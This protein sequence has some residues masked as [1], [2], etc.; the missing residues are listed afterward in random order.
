MRMKKA[1]YL[2]NVF[3]LVLMVIF[4]GFVIFNLYENKRKSADYLAYRDELFHTSINNILGTYEEFSRFIFDTAINSESVCS[5]VAKAGAADEDTK[6]ELRSSLYEDLYDLYEQTQNY[7]FRQLHFHLSDGESFLRFHSPENFGDPLFPVRESVRIA[8][9]EKRF[10]SGFEE[11]RI[12]NGY[13]FVYPLFYQNEPIGSVEISVSVGS[14]IQELNDSALRRDVGF[15]LDKTLVESTVFSE[16][17]ERYTTSDVSEDYVY[18]KEV[19]ALIGDSENSL[20]LYED[21]AFTQ[22]LKTEIAGYLANKESFSLSLTHNNRAYLIQYD[23]ICDISGYPAGYLFSIS[24]NSF[25]RDLRTERIFILCFSPLSLALW[26]LCFSYWPKSKKK[27]VT[28]RCWI[29]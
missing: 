20:R 6:A 26:F 10:V 2:T 11:G 1:R 29:N 21:D 4:L 23:L 22:R 19:F 24:E 16:E 3:V 8:N 15:I 28:T 7:N 18:D 25:I 14:V 9:E 27:C 5:I 13:R 12:M 17:Q